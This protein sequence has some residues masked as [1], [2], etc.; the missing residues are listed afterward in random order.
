[1]HPKA[2]G[3]CT[4]GAAGAVCWAVQGRDEAATIK[5]AF[6]ADCSPALHPGMLFWP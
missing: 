6:V 2:M 4:D 3:G 1:M 5:V